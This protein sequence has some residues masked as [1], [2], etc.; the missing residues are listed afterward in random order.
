MRR[1][2]RKYVQRI[3]EMQRILRYLAAAIQS[4]EGQ[5]VVCLSKIL[6]Q[7]L[8][9]TLSHR[10]SRIASVLMSNLRVPLGFTWHSQAA[11]G[12]AGLVLHVGGASLGMR[13]PDAFE[14]ERFFDTHLSSTSQCRQLRHLTTG[15]VLKI[16]P[17]HY[18][19][20]LPFHCACFGNLATAEAP[21]ASDDSHIG[22]KQ[23]HSLF[24]RCKLKP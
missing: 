16:I 24:N 15:F 1:P 21:L 23:T 14:A 5:L 12:S 22:D 8:E 13:Y 19:V 6:P 11:D 3:E 18:F 4:T 20:F 2:Y 7:T 17:I 9:Q 10:K